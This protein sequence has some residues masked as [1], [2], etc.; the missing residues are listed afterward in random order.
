MSLTGWND[1]GN[2][3]KVPEAAIEDRASD[4]VTMRGSANRIK[5]PSFL[6]LLQVGGKGCSKRK[7]QLFFASVAADFYQA[8]L[9]LEVLSKI[10]FEPVSSE[11]SREH[12]VHVILFKTRVKEFGLQEFLSQDF[13]IL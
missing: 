1:I 3:S 2:A 9:I 10:A 12:A 13:S 5:R 8:F 7:S 6:K 4:R 11:Q